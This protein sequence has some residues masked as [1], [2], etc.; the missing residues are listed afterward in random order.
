MAKTG[1]SAG[2]TATDGIS[3]FDLSGRI[4]VF[5]LYEVFEMLSSG[6]K[7][8]VLDVVAPFGEGKCSLNRGSMLSATMFRL[9]D[10]EAV[11]E[12]LSTKSGSFSFASTASND[13]KGEMDLTSLLMET[14]RLED[15]FERISSYFPDETTRLGL[16]SRG[17]RVV[18]DDLSCGAPHVLEVIANKPKITTPQLLA[19]I[20]LASLKIRLAVAWLS[21]SG[22]LGEYNT[23][24][25]T[26]QGIM[27]SWHQKLLFLGGGG[28]RILFASS[29]E[30]GPEEIFAIISAIAQDCAAPMP[31]ITLPHDGP[32]V[33]R[34]RPPT[35]GLLSITVLPVHKRHR[36]TFQSLAASAQLVA[37]GGVSRSEEGSIWLGLIP[38]TTGLAAWDETQEGPNSLR[39]A[40]REYADSRM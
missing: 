9:S 12:M 3:R 23:Q 7:S 33:V 11:I 20:P 22:I 30:H 39:D 38:E 29:S 28:S 19:A 24:A 4:E 37:M 6:R 10:H 21:S 13:L 34:L 36:G 1:K 15:E 17:L 31:E 25:I 2:P 16:S 27:D 8:G 35:G 32:G 5:S 18:N 40:L 14:V 26:L